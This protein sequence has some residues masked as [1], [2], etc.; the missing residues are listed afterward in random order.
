V[1][2]LGDKRWNKIC[3]HMKERSEIQCFQR[4]LELKDTEFTSKG[5]WTQDEDSVLKGMVE[6]SGAKNWSVIAS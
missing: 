1:E 5:P 3:K 4:W 2:K 6:E